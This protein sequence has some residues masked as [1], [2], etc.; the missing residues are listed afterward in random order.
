MAPSS[1]RRLVALALPPGPRVLD[2]LRAAW[3]GGDAVA[4]LAPDV[5]DALLRVLVDELRPHR[6]VTAT[7]VHDLPAGRPVA[8]DVAVVVATSGSTGAPKGVELTRAALEASARAATARLGAD[9]GDRWL[10]CVPVSHVAGIGV[11]VRALIAGRAPVVHERFDVAAVARERDAT[12]VSLVP[13]MLRRLLEAGADVAHWRA[14]LLGGAAA[15]RALLDRAAAAG[16]RVVRSYGATE[17]CGGCVYDGVPLDGVAVATAD[18]GRISVRGPVLMHGYRG[19]P[20]LTARA[21]SDGWFETGDVGR[22]DDGGRLEV[23]GRADDVVVTGGE[24]VHPARVAA[25]LEE[26]PGVRAAAVVGRPDPEW[27]QRVVAVVVPSG[28]RPPSLDDLR[29]FV[30]IRAARHEAPRELVVVDELPLLPSGKV[31]AAR[32]LGAAG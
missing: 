20:E 15:P 19:R 8:D 3:D 2:A 6:L 7:G 31:D 17:T 14:I 32:A 12:L 16:A 18:D 5:P 13:T 22:F 27:G 11:L 1:P 9:A 23:L 29:T 10:C 25:L 24:K 26:H 28:A 4:P 30:R 21:L